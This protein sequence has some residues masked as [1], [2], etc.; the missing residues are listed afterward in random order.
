MPYKTVILYNFYDSEKDKNRKRNFIFFIEQA[1]QPYDDIYCYIINRGKFD[2]DL[3]VYDRI[4]KIDFENKGICINGYKFALNHIDIFKFD[5]ILLI[6]DSMIGPFTKNKDWRDPF[7]EKM[8]LG[9]SAVAPYIRR[10]QTPNYIISSCMFM[11]KQAAIQ[12]SCF[13]NSIII[14]TPDKALEIEPKISVHLQ[15][16]GFGFDGLFS[17][18]WRDKHTLYDVVFE[19]ENRIGH[20]T[21][22][23]KKSSVET[24]KRKLCC[25]SR[26]DL[27]N[28]IDKLKNM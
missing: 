11:T 23:L 6:N 10:F 14:D 26:Q 4:E 9:N 5:E 22:I 20:N 3:S 2:I 15:K 17:G 1:V 21:S 16:L 7:R 24:P 25:I 12:L 13:L 27:N 19:K 8:N 18:H 28:E